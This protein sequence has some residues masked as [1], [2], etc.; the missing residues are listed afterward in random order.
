MPNASAAIRK[1]LNVP[2][3][4]VISNAQSDCSSESITATNYEHPVFHNH[5]LC[6]IKEGH[7]MGKAEPLFKRITE[8]EVKLLKEKFGGAKQPQVVEQ[9][10]AAKNKK[11][12]KPTAA[13]SLTN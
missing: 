3:F 9:K 7:Q 5:L 6:F 11:T 10:P 12:P 8:D 1:Q 4:N 13:V 2:T